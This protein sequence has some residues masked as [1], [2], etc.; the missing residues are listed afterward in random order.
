MAQRRPRG[1]QEYF[2]RQLN[3]PLDSISSRGRL[4]QDSSDAARCEFSK[5]LDLRHHGHSPWELWQHARSVHWLGMSPM[6]ALR[7]F[8]SSV[9]GA[10]FF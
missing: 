8:L 3:R 2:R 5:T 7:R 10:T 9:I 6:R 1:N 4:A